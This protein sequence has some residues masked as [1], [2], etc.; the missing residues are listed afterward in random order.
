MTTVP[1]DPGG[2]PVPRTSPEQWAWPG[3]RAIAA[4]LGKL[5][6]R[7]EAGDPTPE[8][9]EDLRS[10]SES[11]PFVIRVSE[12][13]G[14]MRCERCS[15]FV[16]AVPEALARTPPESRKWERAIWEPETGRKHTLRRCEAMRGTGM[17]TPQREHPE[18]A[19]PDSNRRSST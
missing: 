9:I 11:A 19:G 2:W 6:A 1:G 12:S 5:R 18:L 7:V 3:E 15:T 8:I 14:L 4:W 16:V 13:R 10:L 17:T